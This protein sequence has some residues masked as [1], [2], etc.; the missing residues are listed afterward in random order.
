[1]AAIACLAPDGTIV[2]LACL[3]A[4][5]REGHRGEVVG[6]AVPGVGLARRSVEVEQ[7]LG[8]VAGVL[9]ARGYVAHVAYRDALACSGV[10][11]HV[12][13]TTQDAFGLAVFVP[14][15]GHEVPLLVGACHHV[16]AEVN[17]P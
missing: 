2:A 4:G 12:V 13:G 7:V 10:D 16:G 14:V 8:T 3:E 15:V 6:C 9:V 11:D 17:P 5:Q 1:M